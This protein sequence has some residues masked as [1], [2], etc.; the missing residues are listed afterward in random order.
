MARSR[1]RHF[2]SLRQFAQRIGASDPT[3]S[4]YKLP[5]PDAIVG[6]VNEDGS[7]PRGTTRGWLPETIDGWNAKRPGRGARTDLKEA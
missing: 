5:E 2:L 1:T 3:L 4:G 7:L 6:P